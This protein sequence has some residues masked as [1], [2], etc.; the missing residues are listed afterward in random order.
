M[1]ASNLPL[2]IEALD[3]NIDDLEDTIFP[4]IEVALS[5]TA[6]KLPVLDRAKLYVLVTY[7]IESIL[8]S[9]LRLAGINAK[10]HPVFR[11]LTRV[12][13]YFEKVK[14][15]EFGEAKRETLSLDKPAVGRFIKHA[16]AGN[17][18]YDLLHAQQQAVNKRKTFSPELTPTD[19]DVRD[20]DAASVADEEPSSIKTKE[21][22]ARPRGRKKTKKTG[23]GGD[24][25]KK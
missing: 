18:Q 23:S 2:L 15:A 7:A 14:I 6:G 5:D 24:G 3:D 1:E 16:L 22:S 25:D 20:G 4:L 9:Y 17:A 21:W 12:K 19:D 11:E 8:F 13:Q 10:E